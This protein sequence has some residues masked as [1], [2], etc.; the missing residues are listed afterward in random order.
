MLKKISLFL[1][2]VMFLTGCNSP[3]FKEMYMGKKKSDKAE[4]APDKKD[5]SK[6]SSE[7]NIEMMSASDINASE[8]Q[9]LM[10]QHRSMDSTRDERR[11]K[12]FGGWTP[13]S[14]K[15]Q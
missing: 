11:R 7:K 13:E 6:Y 5:S 3:M 9:Y 1:F 14:K 10:D 2:P 15:D 8:R 4:K 12:I